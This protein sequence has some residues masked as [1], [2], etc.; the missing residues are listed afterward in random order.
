MRLARKIV[1][2]SETEGHR[3][4]RICWLIA[5]LV[6]SS[7]SVSPQSI[8]SLNDKIV[9][10]LK[11]KEPTGELTQDAPFKD[12]SSSGIVLLTWKINAVSSEA[13]VVMS[14]K[15]DSALEHYRVLNKT[16][17]SPVSR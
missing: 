10:S 7:T 15:R 13:I 4:R 2:L 8:F 6:L 1:L 3:M 17:H 11:E 12:E 16:N 14:E 9:K 5:I